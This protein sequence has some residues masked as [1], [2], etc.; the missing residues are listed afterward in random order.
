MG[1]ACSNG[2][3][4]CAKAEQQWKWSQHASEPSRQRDVHASPCNMTP[5]KGT[6]VASQHAYIHVFV[7][8][9]GTSQPMQESVVAL[10]CLPCIGWHYRHKLP[11]RDLKVVLGGLCKKSVQNEVQNTAFKVKR[12]LHSGDCSR[13][14]SESPLVQHEHLIR[15]LLRR[16]HGDL[17]FFLHRLAPCELCSCPDRCVCARDLRMRQSRAKHSAW[18]ASPVVG[19]CLQAFQS[20]QQAWQEP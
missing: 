12:G 17:V 5:L 19:S 11:S 1:C 18:S 16:A 13:V 9:A 10:Q 20:L 14:G 2:N 3:S 6:S 8:P 7:C 15:Q 4:M